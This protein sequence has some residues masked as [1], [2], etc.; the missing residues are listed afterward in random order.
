MFVVPEVDR[1]LA[2]LLAEMTKVWPRVDATQ[3]WF[4]TTTVKPSGY[5]GK[6]S[7]RC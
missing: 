4:A 1:F 3:L 7:V 2:E 6:G 5:F